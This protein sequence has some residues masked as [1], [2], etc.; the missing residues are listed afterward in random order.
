MTLL[1][2]GDA[3]EITLNEDERYYLTDALKHA[4]SSA[5]CGIACF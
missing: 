5:V 1:T 3:M 2:L 4:I